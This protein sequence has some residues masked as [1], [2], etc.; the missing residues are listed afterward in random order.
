MFGITVFVASNVQPMVL[1]YKGEDAQK[2]ALE[3]LSSFNSMAMGA[4]SKL[5]WATLTDDFGQRLDL[6]AAPLAILVQDMNQAREADI[7]RGIFNMVT[8]AKANERAKADPFLVQQLRAQ[9]QGPAV[10]TPFQMPGRH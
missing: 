7:M 8:Q 10:M 3:A 1:L 6:F 5:P 4:G 9:Q 2:V